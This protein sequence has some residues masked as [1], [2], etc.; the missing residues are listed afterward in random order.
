RHP[1]AI[2]TLFSG[3]M[4]TIAVGL[5]FFAMVPLFAV[6]GMLLYN[7]GSAFTIDMLWKLPPT[8]G[9][10][11]GGFGNAIIGTLAMVGI[12][13]LMSVPFGIL[14]AVYIGEINPDA[15]LA[16]LVRFCTKLLTGLPSILA[17]VFAFAAIVLTTGT[18]S[19]IA[20]SI[21][22]SVLM[23]PTVIVTAEDAIK[24]VPAKMKNAAMGMGATRTQ[25]ILRVVLPTAMPG[26]ATGVFLAV[27]RAM[28]ETAPLIFTALFSQF[29]LWEKG[30]MSET[31]SLAV[32]IY[33]F[34]GSPDEHMI[35]M[36][37]CASLVL[38]IMVLVFNVLAQ[39][40]ARR[41]AQR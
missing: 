32:L 33:N 17:G 41:Q 6:L 23:L 14:A 15:K 20:G 39:V 34:S 16:S 31:S 10:G 28:G 1:T 38:V 4:S 5:T 18:A 12:A 35:N 9:T 25:M 36:A 27:A 21:A 3:T 22:L 26:I 11:G 30:L 37:W 19:A 7:G 29:W 40:L 8:M 24:M 13:C 2:R